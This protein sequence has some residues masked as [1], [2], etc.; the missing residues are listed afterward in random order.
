MSDGNSDA[1]PSG[2]VYQDG[3]PFD[4]GTRGMTLREWYAGM[5]LQGYLGNDTFTSRMAEESI[6]TGNMRGA[7]EKLS[8]A[9]VLSADA[10]LKEL[11][12]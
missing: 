9:S 2:A 10:L 3:E 11:E 4:T 8:K 6:A 5:A 7:M 12:K 1:F